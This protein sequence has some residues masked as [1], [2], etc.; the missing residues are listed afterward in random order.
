MEI[1]SIACSN[2]DIAAE[3]MLMEC[4][5][6]TIRCLRITLYF[7]Y[8]LVFKSTVLETWEYS[9]TRSLNIKCI[10]YFIKNQKLR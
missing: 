10:K 8:E 7:I 3:S 6:G 2:P 9:K 1:S 4:C 5:N